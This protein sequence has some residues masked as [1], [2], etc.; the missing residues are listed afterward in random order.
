MDY[1]KKSVA[2][3]DV[4]GKKILMRCDFN[5]PLENGVIMDD[6][7]IQET[8]PTIN[9]LLAHGASVILCSHMGRPKGKFDEKYSLKP[10]AEHLSELLGFEVP[11]A[12]DVI[13]ETAHELCDAV[14]PGRAVLLENIRFEPGEEANDPTFAR[15]LASFADIFVND[16]FG[17]AHRAHASTC[18]VAKYLPAVCGFLME[19]E[20]SI[21]GE[22]RTEPQHPFVVIMGG[23]KVSDKLLMIENL[24]PRADCTMI[25]GGMAYTFIKALGG[26]IGDSLCDDERI[27][28]CLRMVELAKKENVRLVLPVDVVAADEF[29]NDANRQIVDP[30]HIPEGWQALDIGPKTAKMCAEI[31]KGARSL[32]WNGPTGVFEMSNFSNGTRAIAEAVAACEGVTIVGGGDSASAV[33]QFGL[34]DKI[35]HVSTGGGAS[36]EFLEGKVLPGVA[37]LMDK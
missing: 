36:L 34:K 28:V 15:T 18:G 24:M 16:A 17:A 6:A 8:M 14:Q 11:L 12:H 35:T 26:S 25:L 5:V 7:R 37:C 1:H 27:D 3:I 29:S 30:Y 23:G 20:I 33:K 22:I 10:V 31:I 32:I 4:T 19:K 13:G 2:D 9:Y 21:M